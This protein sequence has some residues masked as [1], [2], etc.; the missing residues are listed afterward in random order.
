MIKFLVCICLFLS[1][2]FSAQSVSSSSSQIYDDMLR[3]QNNT[4]VMYLAAHPDDENTKII[5]WL[6]HEKHVDAVYLSLN[7]GGG[8]QNLVGTEKGESLGLLRTQELLRA[9]KIDKGRQWFTRAMDF[10]FSKTA[11][12]TLKLWD[13]TEAFGR[14]CLGNS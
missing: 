3:L 6:T 13:E 12:E 1:I 8:G 9:R 4:T 11:T 2:Q 14:C 7:R 10:G 5:S